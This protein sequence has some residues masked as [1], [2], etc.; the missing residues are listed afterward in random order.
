MT[1]S[2]IW[3]KLFVFVLIVGMF[4]A[5]I[6]G[7]WSYHTAK[8]SL[9]R[10]ALEH[11]ISI[12]NIKKTQIEDYFVERLSNTEVLASADIFRTYLEEVSQRA[13][14]R[15]DS[16]DSKKSNKM[17][18]QRFNKIAHVIINKMGF[19]DIFV[20][21]TKGN[22]LQTIAKEDDFGTNLVS[23]KYKDT[24]LARVFAKG[25]IEPAISDIEFYAP[26]KEKISAFFAAPV[27][28]DKGNVLGVLA[29]Q[30]TM[31]YIDEI[32]QERSGLG[33]TGETIL[34]GHDLF[35]RSNSR[36]SK[37]PTTLKEKIDV[38]AP[39]RALAGNTGA[40]W[41]LDYRNVPVFNAYAPLEISGL[42][43]VIISKMDEREIL[44][45]VNKFRFLLLIGL[46]ILAALIFLVSYVF[47][48]KLTRPVNLLTNN[49]LEMAESGRYD[50]SIAV[51]TE[52]EIGL[53]VESFNKMSLQ[54][55][56][57]TID[58]KKNQK[59]LETE[60][61]ERKQ[62]ERNLQA[63]QE[64]LERINKE[65]E[66]QNSLKTALH[67]LYSCMLGEQELSEL[68]NN[69]LMFIVTFLDLPLGAL[70]IL[71]SGN[72]LQRVANYGYPKSRDI[73]ESFA[74]GT[75]LV[76]QTALEGKPIT[77]R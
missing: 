8:E 77:L 18:A 46:G 75:G 64:K 31:K 56:K 28:D 3:R 65:I 1:K 44:A 47:A 53:L 23:G 70:F 59:K 2:K 67:Q 7:Y 25:L 37:D 30:I 61:I 40:L 32:M 4:S 14:N 63:N 71:N 38:E 54:I 35:M 74:L 69:I 36:F 19:Y 68:G 15:I 27:K 73:P 21:D 6:T 42:N 33:K 48:R 45:P 17:F 39:R 41:L 16:M 52:D 60:L 11:L 9:E 13:E 66:N 62:A 50:Q 57:Q 49:L 51:T 58:L 26:S 22:I 20:I 43:W 12:R 10:G 29:S 34:V 24:S 76:G 72:L 55:H 5:G